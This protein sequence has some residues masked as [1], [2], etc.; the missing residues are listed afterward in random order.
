[1]VARVSDHEDQIEH[2]HADVEDVPMNRMR[3]PVASAGVNA[4]VKNLQGR[5]KLYSTVCLCLLDD[6]SRDTMAEQ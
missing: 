1:M 2:V 4:G 3:R 5:Q 6:T